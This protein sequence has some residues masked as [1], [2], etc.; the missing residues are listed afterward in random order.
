MGISPHWHPLA[1]YPQ[2]RSQ[3]SNVSLRAFC[4]RYRESPA[5]QMGNLKCG[6][7]SILLHSCMPAFFCWAA[8]PF[9]YALSN[10][11]GLSSLLPNATATCTTTSPKWI[12]IYSCALNN[13]LERKNMCIGK[14][15]LASPLHRP[16]GTEWLKQRVIQ[17]FR[18]EMS[19]IDWIVVQN[20]GSWTRCILKCL[21]WNVPVLKYVRH[22]YGVP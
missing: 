19:V 1:T 10:R 12:R 7:G 2:F 21:F 6:E 5:P 15:Y 16:P 20:E 18:D 22:L 11:D 13:C 14:W 4:F 9:L 8:W 17:T 3:N